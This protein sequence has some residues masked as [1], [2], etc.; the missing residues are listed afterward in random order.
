MIPHFAILIEW[1]GIPQNASL[2]G[3]QIDS[4]NE[5]VHWFML[6]LFVG[7]AL[8][9]AYSLWRFAQKRNNRASYSGMK[10]HGSSHVEYGVIIFEAV[11]LL[12]FAFPLWASRVD[13]NEYPTGDDVVRVDA[14]AYQFGWEFHYPGKDKVLGRRSYALVTVENPLGIDF[15]DPNAADD[16]YTKNK[17]VVPVDQPVICNVSSKD[18]IHNYAVK[19][20]RIGQDAIPGMQIPVIYT[21]IRKGKFEIVCAQLC[22]SGHYSMKAWLE[23]T[24]QDE[25]G[26][27]EAK[28]IDNAVKAREA[29]A[30]AK[31]QKALEEKAKSAQAKAEIKATNS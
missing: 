19:H 28:Q 10:G 18:V 29:L 17:M 8:F 1:M 21:P 15:E 13:A 9:F 3:E 14:V 26:E 11:L 6:A 24:P 4:F 22:G 16:F 5:L 31:A 25:Y 27:W 30:A 23:V 20:M 12:G 2:H 7:W